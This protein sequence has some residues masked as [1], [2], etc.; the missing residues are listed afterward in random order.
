MSMYARYSLDGTS[1]DGRV[2]H[3][4]FEFLE[5]RREAFRALEACAGA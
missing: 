2:P 5:A 3:A 4:L 1:E